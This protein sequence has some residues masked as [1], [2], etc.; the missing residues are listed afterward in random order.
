LQLA[1]GSR[2][3]LIAINKAGQVNVKDLPTC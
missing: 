2:C 1:D 3:S